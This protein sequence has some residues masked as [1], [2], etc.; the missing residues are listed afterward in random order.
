MA[1][2]KPEFTK[3]TD[4]AAS[5]L[6][7]KVLYAN[8]D[9]FAA[10]ENLIQPGRGVFIEGKYTDHG[11]WMD[12]WETRR[13]RKPGHDWCVIQLAVA[14][15]I[16]GFDI[17]TNHFLGNHPPFAS[18]DGARLEGPVSKEDIQN[19]QI[20][21]EPLLEQ[22]TL[23]PGSQNLFAINSE[24]I[25]THLRLNI[26]PDGGVARLR[27]YGEVY[28]DWSKVAEDELVDLAAML[29]GGRTLSCNDMF[30]S[31]MQNLILPGPGHNMGDGWETKRSRV[32]G[33]CDWVILQLAKPGV[34]KKILVDTLY[35]M[36]NYPDQCSLEGC[37]CKA[38]A[39]EAGTAEWFPILPKCKL[40]A[41]EEHCFEKE[42]VEHGK[43]SHVRFNIFPDGGV[44]RLRLF[45][46]LARRTD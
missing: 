38:G 40:E 37:Y 18:V 36:G 27:C 32:P 24:K 33:N 26:F 45:G 8:D 9:F 34:L 11:K 1:E 5:R 44:S 15:K 16:S 21:W 20:A 30:F 28:K 46:I 29:N 13:R 12:G 10:K 35:F 17:D 3:L 25:Y 22:S 31:Q 14:G 43:A 39:F 2:A 4:L 6:G 42:I 23:E 41:D 19:G 7:G